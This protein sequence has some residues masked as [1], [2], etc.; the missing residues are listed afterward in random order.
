MR[1]I[2]SIPII[3]SNS[4][5][6]ALAATPDNTIIILETG[7]SQ[8]TEVAS[9]IEGLN[10][11]YWKLDENERTRIKFCIDTCHI[12]ATGY[13]ISTPAGVKAFFKEF[14]DMIGID[15]IALIHFNDSKTQLESCV[16]RHADLGYGFIKT[17]G[18]K[19]VAKFAFK[20]RIPLLTETPLDA[21]DIKSNKDITWQGEFA[22][23]KSWLK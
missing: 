11:I 15:K 10:E 23:I 12:W 22:K 18:L 16:D 5:K 14:D 1:A 20:N 8:G 21:I 9:K 13:D 17:T 2:L 6:N 4:L 7:A 3:S 19:A